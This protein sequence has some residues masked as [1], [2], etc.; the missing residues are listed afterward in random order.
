MLLSIAG[1]DV[2]RGQY[3][4]KND[5]RSDIAGEKTKRERK[6]ENGEGICEMRTKRRKPNNK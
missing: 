4:V 3:G 5:S 6:G 2:R 1:A